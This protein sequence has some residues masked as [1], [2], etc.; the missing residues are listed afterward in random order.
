VVA[1]QA[2]PAPRSARVAY[3][4]TDSTFVGGPTS[5]DNISDRLQGAREAPVGSGASISVIETE[6]RNIAAS[7]TDAKLMGVTPLS[8]ETKGESI[9]YA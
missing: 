7:I 8:N 4:G 1:R 3:P 6:D 9:S 5:I 2:T